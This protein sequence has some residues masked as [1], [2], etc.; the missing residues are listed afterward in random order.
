MVSSEK[1]GRGPKLSSLSAEALEKEGHAVEELAGNRARTLVGCGQ[2]TAEHRVVIVDPQTHL[3]CEPGRVGEIWFAGNSVAKGYWLHPEETE[4]TFHAR[5][6]G[7]DDETRFLRTGD[8]GFF[9]DGELFVTG[10]LKDL[11]ILRGRNFYPQ[12]IEHTVER[13][14]PALN[15]GACAAVSID[16]EGEE[17]LVIIQE[18][19]RSAREIDLEE[20][21][22]AIHRDVFESYGI[23][24]YAISL[25]RPNS[26]PMTSS[27]KI[28]RQLSRQ[29]YLGS[30]LQEVRRFVTEL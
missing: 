2:A 8:L 13:S 27:G 30:R 7:T 28:R 25:I 26:I 5:L 20:V 22:A 11:V 16:E 4:Q 23:N 19:S 12:D 9:H 15:V 3:A 1:V 6:A 18:L 14:H 21:V 17:R 10:R 24:P 29:L